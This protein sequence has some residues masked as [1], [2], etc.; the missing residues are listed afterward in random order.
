MPNSE[1]LIMPYGDFTPL[2]DATS[3]IAP[4]AVVIGDVVIKAHAGVYFNC[5]L[6]G[7][8]NHIEVGEGS[9][10]QDLTMMHIDDA[11]PCIV[12]DEVTVGHRAL[13][14]GCV[15]E[16]GCLIGMGAV[17]LN[18]VVVGRGSVVAAGAVVPERMVIP[19]GSL[20]AG[21]PAV[22]K[23]QLG[24]RTSGSL[25]MW[26]QKYRKVAR[27]FIT[28]KPFRPNLGLDPTDAD[29]SDKD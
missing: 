9:N 12:G 23:K 22:V 15:V 11:Y 2:I 29:S 1:P 14:H 21:V 7:D 5:V 6:R 18:G 27:A 4:G 25:T 10:I 8:I 16:D 20:V 26:A 13:L 3:Y 17:L 19:P 24:P 28:G